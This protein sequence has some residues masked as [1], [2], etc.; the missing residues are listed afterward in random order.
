MSVQHPELAAGRWS[1]LSLVEQLANVGSE[2]ERALRWRAK[3]QEAYGR[4]AFKRAL[5]LIDL[6]L[7]DFKNA[8]RLKEVARLRELFVDNFFGSN[9]YFS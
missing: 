5:E 2:V 8:S 1:Q 6:T 4:Q 7:A 9:Q 3:H